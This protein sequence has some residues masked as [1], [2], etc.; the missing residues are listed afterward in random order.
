MSFWSQISAARDRRR[1]VR[2]VPILGVEAS[3]K[4]SLI[5]TLGQ[6]ISLHGMG[7]ISI[8]SSNLFGDLLATVAAG[9]PLP[10]SVRWEKFE[11]H[12]D[13]VPEPGGGYTEVDLILSSE[14]I[15][16]RQFRDL[17]DELRAN[18]D[19]STWKAGPAKQILGELT[20]LLSSC[21]GF[22]FLIDLMRDRSSPLEAG[23]E[24]VWTAF[25]DQI[26][27][28]M[29]GILLA[30]KMNAVMAHKPVFFV[31]S[32]PDLHGLT[33]AEVREHFRRGMA[34]PL[35]QLRGELI[36][37]RHYDVQCAGWR[38]DSALEGLGIRALLSDLAHAVDAVPLD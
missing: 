7:R 29:T 8:G 9:R 11:L 26:K 10:A 17:V 15:P 6:F 38:L 19:L 28:I 5:L 27:P 3:G 16:G 30:S 18:P 37:V 25:A 33:P 35:A 22:I 4:S 23:S 14:D 31:F 34:I 1:R 12:V 13:R 36:N 21:D 20:R 2:K 24:Q 32:K